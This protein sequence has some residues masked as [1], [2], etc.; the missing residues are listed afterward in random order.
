MHYG[1]NT[2]VDQ[3]MPF[4]AQTTPAA[5]ISPAKG[6]PDGPSF[7]TGDN[8]ISSNKL[9]GRDWDVVRKHVRD[10]RRSARNRIATIL[11]TVEEVEDFSYLPVPPEISYRV[12]VVFRAG[13]Q[14]APMQL[15]HEFDDEV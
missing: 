7:G 11:A 5:L 14:I 9:R 4:L 10:A 8:W 2:E 6:D 13:S 12:H 1:R 3:L 15:E